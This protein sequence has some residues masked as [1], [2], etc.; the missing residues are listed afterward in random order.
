MTITPPAAEIPRDARLPDR[1]WQKVHSEG[2]CWLW[3]AAKDRAGYGVFGLGARTE[4]TRR[5]HIVA[6]EALVGI[7][8]AGKMLDH[9]CRNKSCVNPAHLLPATRSENAQNLSGGHRDSASGVRGVYWEKS[10]NRWTGQVCVAGVKHGIGHYADLSEAEAA[11]VA[12]RNQLHTNN[13]ADRTV[14]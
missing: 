5:A 10:R 11:I 6:Y 14:R 13:L 3:I 7:V 8:P 12:L 9:Q 2:G 4:G 1:F